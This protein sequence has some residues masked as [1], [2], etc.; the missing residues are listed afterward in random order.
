M[1]PL[2]QVFVAAAGAVPVTRNVAGLTIE[3][4]AVPALHQAI[5]DVCDFVMCV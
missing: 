3:G 4:M 5:A 2:R 1:S